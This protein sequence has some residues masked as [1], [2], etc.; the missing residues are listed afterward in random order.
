MTRFEQIVNIY[1]IK[2]QLLVVTNEGVFREYFNTSYESLGDDFLQRN[3]GIT[4]AE[5]EKFGLEGLIKL[6][7]HVGIAAAYVSFSETIYGEILSES[8]GKNP[9]LNVAAELCFGFRYDIERG[10]LEREFTSNKDLSDEKLVNYLLRLRGPFGTRAYGACKKPGFNEMFG[11][12]IMQYPF[13][14]AGLNY[15]VRDLLEKEDTRR[16][17]FEKRDVPDI[18]AETDL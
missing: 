18:D 12:L 10:E 4:K 13:V 16:A 6:G 9:G 1:K 7:K 15:L 17:R 11:P 2:S 8:Q 3:L 14:M 5:L